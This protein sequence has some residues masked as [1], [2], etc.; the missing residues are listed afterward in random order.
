MEPFSLT[1]P[2]VGGIGAA[3]IGEASGIVAMTSQLRQRSW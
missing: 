3:D 2:S 1:R